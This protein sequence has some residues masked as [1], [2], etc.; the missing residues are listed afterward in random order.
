MDDLIS[1]QTL[2]EEKFAYIECML[3]ENKDK[4]YDIYKKGWNDAIDT[5]YKNAPSAQQWIPCEERLPEI[6]VFALV[7]LQHFNGEIDVVIAKVV[8]AYLSKEL[9]WES[10]DGEWTWGIKHGIAWMP[11]PKPYK[12]SEE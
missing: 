12:E 5:I 6:E 2:L 8:K 1:R 7:T 10:D 3:Q 9:A 4:H 11:L